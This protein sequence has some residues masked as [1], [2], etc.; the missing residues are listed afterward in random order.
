M[1]SRDLGSHAC[2]IALLALTDGNTPQQHM[3]CDE[4]DETRPQLKFDTLRVCLWQR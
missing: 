4:I 1:L 3:R 2:S